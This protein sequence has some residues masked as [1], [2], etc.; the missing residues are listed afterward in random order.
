VEVLAAARGIDLSSSSPGYLR[1]HVKDGLR[2]I[3]TASRLA[4]LIQQLAPHAATGCAPVDASA[5]RPPGGA[6][7]LVR[8][9]A[10]GAL[11]DLVRVEGPPLLFG[12]DPGAKPLVQVYRLEYMG[13]YTF[14]PADACR[15]FTGD[16]EQR[17]DQVGVGLQQ[18]PFSVHPLISSSANNLCHSVSLWVLV[19]PGCQLGNWLR[20][21]CQVKMGPK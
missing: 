18:H 14:I 8:Q 1:K 7:A 6:A 17:H 20:S 9:Q 2:E 5:A 12:D 19:L 21:G 15:I 16:W 3:L 10:P 4:T 13:A 11:M